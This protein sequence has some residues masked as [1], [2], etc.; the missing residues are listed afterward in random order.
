MDLNNQD[1]P[2]FHSPPQINYIYFGALYA[3][4][5][6]L[7][8]SSIFTKE[9]LAGS[10]FF[11]YLYALGQVTLETAFFV[12]L[13]LFIPRYFGKAFFAAFI[14]ATFV[15]LFIHIFDFLMDRI[16]DLSAFEAFRIFVFD[17][18][19]ENFFYLL[20]AS[21]I[22][23]WVWLVFFVFLA[24]LPFIGILLYQI[25][26]T[27]AKKNPI[28]I[29]SSHFLQAFFCIPLA[30]LFWDFSAS[31][32]IHP[33]AYTAFIKAL[34]WKFTFLQPE[35]VHISLPGPL[36]DPISEEKITETIAHDK[37]SLIQ[38]PNIYFFVAESLREDSINEEIA[39]HLFQFKKDSLHLK[40]AISSGNGTHLSWFSIFHSQFPYRW[41]EFQNNR[42]KGSPALRLLKK[43]GYQIRLY[44]SAELAYYGMEELLFGNRLEI[45]DQK[46]RFPHPPP[47]T[48]AESDLAALTKLQNDILE[49]PNL[50]QGQVFLIFWDCTH[51]DYRLP[52]TWNP[53]F[54]P[55]AQ[56]FAYFKAFH[57]KKTIRSIKNRYHNAVNYMDH[58][59]GSF[60]QNLPNKENAIV[61]FTGDH[62]EEF[63]EHGHL[64][65][66]SHLTREQTQVPLYMKLGN[67]Q[68]QKLAL[69]SHIDIFPTLID[70][71]ETNY[72]AD[73]QVLKGGPRTYLE[74]NSLLKKTPWPF[75]VTARF[76][77]GRTPYEFAL[78]NEKYKLIA[79]FF[80]TKEIFATNQLRIVSLRT[81]DDQSLNEE[82]TEGWVK[83]E[84]GEALGRLFDEK[85][86]IAHRSRLLP[87]HTANQ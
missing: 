26:N 36:R 48:A 83:N 64:F 3:I 23:I 63:F 50:Q 53:K 72:L 40:K 12:E 55:S 5:I 82:D 49:N 44:S 51:F 9:N 21:G 41:K 45:L 73:R 29:A 57:S 71:L 4:L 10:Y 54:V 6:V 60:I 1:S 31:K 79:Q 30:L 16:L 56:E 28:P 74:G 39:P 78:H 52:K 80:D 42:T 77:A 7:T 20:D 18:N 75:A 22:S 43:W 24:S 34:P 68:G 19:L 13:S 2:Y 33:D 8:S 87:I 32:I 14:G 38:K 62:G 86:G 25:S 84:F 85:Q 65:H 27:L 58:L 37:T 35:N 46:E 76:N 47:I 11:F 17:E 15:T 69:G 59:F 81:Q 67:L 61:I 66:N 70:F